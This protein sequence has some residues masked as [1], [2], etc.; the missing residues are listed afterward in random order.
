MRTWWS[1]AAV[2]TLVLL[3]PCSGF[4][5][6]AA[7]PEQLVEQADH[8]AWLRNWIRAEPLYSEARRLF[9]ARN[10]HRN[11]LYAEI[12]TLRAQLPGLP[13]PEVSQRLAEYLDDPIVQSDQRLRLRTLVIK[14]ET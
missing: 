5:E 9:V 13:V 11:A 4:S 6:Q 1:A 10:H 3:L 12:N 14:G 8:L 7:D 2:F